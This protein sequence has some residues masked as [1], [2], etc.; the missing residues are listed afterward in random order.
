MQNVLGGHSKYD[1]GYSGNMKAHR[2]DPA[3]FSLPLRMP[4]PT[5]T[6]FQDEDV[7]TLFPSMSSWLVQC[8]VPSS[9]PIPAHHHTSLYLLTECVLA[10]SNAVLMVGFDALYLLL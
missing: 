3:S 5:K 9:V 4:L 1:R 10:P 8:L 7:G 2:G 6:S